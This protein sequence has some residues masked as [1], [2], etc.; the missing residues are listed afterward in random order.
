MRKRQVLSKVLHFKEEYGII[1]INPNVITT[2]V[3]IVDH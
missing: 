1:L 3:Y 2:Y